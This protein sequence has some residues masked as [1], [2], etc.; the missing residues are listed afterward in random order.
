M[1]KQKGRHIFL[2]QA[3]HAQNEFEFVRVEFVKE[4]AQ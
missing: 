1:S 4:V 3:A 2:S